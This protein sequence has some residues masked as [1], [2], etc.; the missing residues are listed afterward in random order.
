MAKKNFKGGLGSLIQDSRKESK[1]EEERIEQ[2]LKAKD[3]KQLNQLDNAE[4]NDQIKWLLHK[5][6]DYEKEL[7]LWR[8]GKLTLEK[9]KKSLENRDLIYNED[10]QI[11]EKK[12]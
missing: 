1:E 9:F 5:I 3:K 10:K 12:S 11:F 8:T 6:K 4:S 2:E 7:H